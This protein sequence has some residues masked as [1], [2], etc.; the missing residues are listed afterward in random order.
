MFAGG[1]LIVDTFRQDPSIRNLELLGKRFY[2]RTPEHME[3]LVA[4]AGFANPQII[5]SGNIFDVMVRMV[6]SSSII[7]ILSLIYFPSLRKSMGQTEKNINNHP[8]FKKGGIDNQW[9]QI[10][11]F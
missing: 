6:S 1:K 5:T 11:N 4:T 2:F 8:K 3:N 9:K 7:K 10:K